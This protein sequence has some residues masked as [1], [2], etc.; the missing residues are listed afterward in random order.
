MSGG[1]RPEQ[2][3]RVKLTARGAVAFVLVASVA[4]HA[5]AALTGVAA[6]SG[7]S[8]V[9]ACLAGVALVNPRD[10]LALVVA[11]PLVFLVAGIVA[12][13]VRA[14]GAESVAQTF[15]LGMFTALSAGAPWLFAGSAVV[16]VVAWRRGLGGNVREL[17]QELAATRPES[18]R[19]KRSEAAPAVPKARSAGRDRAR[20][21][22]KSRENAVYAPEPEGYFE[23][24][25]YGTA[26]NTE[27]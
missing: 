10:L 18:R 7:L 12:E 19:G 2:R 25:V 1:S 21:K 14:I 26:R 24:T 17:R 20:S 8:F 11:P 3:S 22:D 15:A 9:A 5:L 6:L 13:A 4:G 23:P 16:L 27:R